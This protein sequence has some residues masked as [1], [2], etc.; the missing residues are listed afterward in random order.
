MIC[1]FG[2][3]DIDASNKICLGGMV[4]VRGGILLGSPVQSGQIYHSH[5]TVHWGSGGQNDPFIHKQKHLSSLNIIL[6]VKDVSVAVSCYAA[7]SFSTNLMT[8]AKVCGSF[9]INFSCGSVCIPKSFN[10]NEDCC[11]VIV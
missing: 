11:S 4:F 7:L 10:K 2:C 5:N 9:F 8:S 3:G 6:I 1:P